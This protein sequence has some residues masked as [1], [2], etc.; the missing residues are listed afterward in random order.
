MKLKIGTL[1]IIFSL[2]LISFMQ[3]P[4]PSFAAKENTKKDVT[5]FITYNNQH[6]TAYS[7]PQYLPNG[8]PRRTHSGKI[9]QWGYA[10]VHP[11]R[12]GT[13]PVIPF[14]SAVVF[15][16]PVLHPLYG[17]RSSF[18]IEDTGDYGY[19]WSYNFVDIWFGFCTTCNDKDAF[20]DNYDYALNW[21]APKKNYN[22]Y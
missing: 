8:Q 11:V 2:I 1:L 19:N 13:S 12:G 16:T 5:P 15:D 7:L 3:E 17:S 4:K 6:V 14:G 10:A 21:G 18:Q 20:K 22:V 9:P